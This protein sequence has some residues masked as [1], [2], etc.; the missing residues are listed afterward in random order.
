MVVSTIIIDLLY[1]DYFADIR[2]HFIRYSCNCLCVCLSQ[3]YLR[4][5][6]FLMAFK[7]KT[8]W[9]TK[10]SIRNKS[11]RKIYI[12]E[13]SSTNR[14]KWW[15]FDWLWYV[16]W[17]MLSIYSVHYVWVCHRYRIH[18]VIKIKNQLI[19]EWEWQLYA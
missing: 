16:L 12:V 1:H 5:F 18:I 14:V 19:A 2:F 17:A 9:M 7:F 10:P 3:A 11:L 6:A 13:M 4:C 8:N 15:S